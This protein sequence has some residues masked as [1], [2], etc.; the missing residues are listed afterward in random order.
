MEK[1]G[2]IVHRILTDA[3]TQRSA[4]LKAGQKGAGTGND[5]TRP[6]EFDL[7]ERIT[8]T[9]TGDPA[10][11]Q[12]EPLARDEAREGA[13]S[14]A[15]MN[16]VGPVTVSGDDEAAR[17]AIPRAEMVTPRGLARAK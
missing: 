12:R 17:S 5:R 1:F 10:N 13:Q 8:G 16:R 6:G 11:G 7:G 15:F 4:A 14:A 3:W 9:T 2:V